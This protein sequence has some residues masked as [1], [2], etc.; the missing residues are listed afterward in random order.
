MD[1]P[2]NWKVSDDETHLKNASYAYNSKF[3]CVDNKVHL[4]TEYE[5]FKDNVSSDEASNYFRDLT[6]Y[7]EIASFEISS[8][9][10]ESSA[11]KTGNKILFPP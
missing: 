10:E 9:G 5:N 8:G 1:L 3:Y 2:Q 4:M 6:K 11:P 7:D